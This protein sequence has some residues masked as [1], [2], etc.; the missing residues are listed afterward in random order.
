MA[1]VVQMAV[2]NQH[3]S[4]FFICF[5]I[6]ALRPSLL[7]WF[8]PCAP[9]IPIAAG[10]LYPFTHMRLPPEVA[11]L[12]MAASSVSVVTSS[13]LLRRYCPP[14]MPASVSTTTAAATSPIPTLSTSASIQNPLA[15]RLQRGYV[16]LPSSVEPM[17]EGECDV[18]L[19][20]LENV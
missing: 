18:E 12:A 11:G 6:H 20:S 3:M 5:S 8:N 15:G 19:N 10:I 17:R 7:L 13:L 14:A 9:G 1:T 2:P 4:T 16:Q